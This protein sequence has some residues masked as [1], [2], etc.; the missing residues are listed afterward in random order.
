MCYC[1]HS[2]RSYDFYLIE[3]IWYCKEQVTQ[4]QCFSILE[5]CIGLSKLLL[6]HKCT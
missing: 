4:N 5:V 6:N 2:L 1:E 3:V